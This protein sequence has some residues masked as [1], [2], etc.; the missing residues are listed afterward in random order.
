MAN[1]FTIKEESKFKAKTL[2]RS[3]QGTDIGDYFLVGERESLLAPVKTSRI[4]FLHI[5][6]FIGILAIFVRVISLQIFQGS[7]YRGIAEGN[8]I[9]IQRLKADRGLIYDRQYLPLVK[10]VPDFSLMVIP[11]DLPKEPESRYEV[12]DKLSSE[13]GPD[14]ENL[15]VLLNLSKYSY[16]ACAVKESLSYEEAVKLKMQFGQ[17]PGISIGATASRD[18]L[19]PL[20]FSHILGYVGKISPGELEAHPH[21]YI[22]DLTGKTG[23][24][25]VYESYLRGADGKMLIEVSSLG[26]EERVVDKIPAKTG[27]DLILTIDADLQEMITE[28]L[29]KYIAQT[30]SPAGAAVALDPRNGEVLAL[31]SLPSY[32]NNL[33]IRG[34]EQDWQGLIQAPNDPLVNRATAGQ[35]LSGSIIKLVIAAGALSEGIINKNTTIYSQGGIRVGQWF[36][37][38]WKEG[39]HGP[40]NLIKALAESINTFF[41][42]IGGGFGSFKGLGLDKIRYYGELFGLNQRAGIDLDQEAEG[43][44]PTREWASQV[45]GRPWSIGDTYH[46]A[47]GQGDILVTPLQVANMT[48]VVANGGALYRPHLVKEIVD[49]AQGERFEIRPE[50]IRK[51]FINKSHMDLIRQGLRAAVVSGSA[52][53]L[54]DLPREL[55]GKTGTAEVGGEKLPHAWFTGFAPYDEPE[56]VLTILIENGGG[57]EKVAVPAAKEIF[58]YLFSKEPPG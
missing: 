39:G 44:L 12:L 13:L 30:R 49:P 35:Y 57:G 22:T 52:R 27:R 41:Y 17:A 50:I 25:R 4:N 23:L 54:A 2:S 6:V 24:E 45:R 38:D 51:D 55:A 36:Y 7:Y 37:P 8:R 42:Y 33:F 10:N 46:L 29:A 53:R 3:F 18:Y 9:R 26:K 31:V 11:G 15:E 40:T 58:E 14:K 1:P 16:E 21:Y 48:A 28:I 20:A 43:F 19:M 56:I 47:I 5:L 32:N 34:D